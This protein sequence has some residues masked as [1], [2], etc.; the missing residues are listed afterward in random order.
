MQRHRRC[1]SE[2]STFYQNDLG[3]RN[4]A[5]VTGGKPIAVYS[6]PSSGISAVNPLRHPRKKERGTTLS[7]CPGHRMRLFEQKKNWKLNHDNLIFIIQ[8]KT[9][10]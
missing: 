1:S 6:Q 3:M 10:L 4:T 2:T 5:D 7:F 8:K 9:V